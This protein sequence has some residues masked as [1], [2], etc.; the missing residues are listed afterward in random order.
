MIRNLHNQKWNC[1]KNIQNLNNQIFWPETMTM[2]HYLISVNNGT[3]ND[4]PGWR[5]QEKIT[6]KFHKFKLP[7]Y[8]VSQE[9]LTEPNKL[10]FA[11]NSYYLTLINDENWRLW[12]HSNLLHQ[13]QWVAIC[14]SNWIYF[15]RQPQSIYKI[16]RVRA[17]IKICSE[18]KDQ[19]TA[20]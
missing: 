12:R 5:L 20:S 8:S 19:R 3:I 2:D 18:T 1:I 17:L 16:K 9:A 7:W 4:S 15:Q 6:K 11:S 13:V 10:E 14:T